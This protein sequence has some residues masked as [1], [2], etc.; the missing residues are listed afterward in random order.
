MGPFNNNFAILISIIDEKIKTS[1]PL[2]LAKITAKAYKDFDRVKALKSGDVLVYFKTFENTFKAFKSKS[3]PKN[4]FGDNATRRRWY[5]SKNTFVAFNVP[6][7]MEYEDIQK[8]IQARYNVHLEP[9]RFLSRKKETS[10]L[11]IEVGS[12]EAK[13]TISK[14]KK[15]QIGCGYYKITKYRAPLVKQCFKCN[16]YGHTQYACSFNESCKRFGRAH[17]LN[18]C[19]ENNPKCSNCS[20]NHQAN[21]KSCPEYKKLT[22]KIAEKDIDEENRFS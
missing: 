6:T 15:I 18:E 12:S 16:K 11:Y 3:E 9:Y 8:D 2:I 14:L 21:D 20:G 1:N 22:R 10:A 13:E 7:M 4:T 19:K 17:H 5:N